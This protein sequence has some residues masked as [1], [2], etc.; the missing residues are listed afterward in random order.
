MAYRFK[1]YMPPLLPLRWSNPKG[2]ETRASIEWV[3]L[4]KPL[5]R[6]YKCGG[7]TGSAG[8]YVTARSDS[9]NGLVIYDLAV[10]MSR[11]QR[12]NIVVVFGLWWGWMDGW[13]WL[14]WKICDSTCLR[15]VDR[16]YE[17]GLP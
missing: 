10:V 13:P 8:F 11:L 5:N 7:H 1:A 12:E 4:G 6:R 16:F 9:C 17:V 15:Q 14:G 3:Y 2:D